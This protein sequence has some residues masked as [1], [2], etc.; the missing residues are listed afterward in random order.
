[1]KREGRREQGWNGVY[2]KQEAKREGRQRWELVGR[3]RLAVVA[4]SAAAH[5]LSKL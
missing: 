4:S 1:M 2:G 5:Y 3:N